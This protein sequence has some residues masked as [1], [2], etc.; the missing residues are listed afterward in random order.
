MLFQTK[1]VLCIGSARFSGRERESLLR[2]EENAELCEMIE[3]Q[4]VM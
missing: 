2:D 3:Q 4:N 1:H